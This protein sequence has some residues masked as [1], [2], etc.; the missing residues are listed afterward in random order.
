MKKKETTSNF[1][2]IKENQAQTPETRCHLN[3][4]GRTSG[5][6]RDLQRVAEHVPG[7]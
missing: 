1:F 7:W 4:I 2:M 3:V 6:K 5:E